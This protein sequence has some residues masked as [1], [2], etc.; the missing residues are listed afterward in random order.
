MQDSAELLAWLALIRIPGLDAR[1]ASAAVRRHGGAAAL[2]AAQPTALDEDGL[3]PSTLAALAR[4]D[5]AAAERDLAWLE[6]DDCRLLTCADPGYPLQLA[7]VPGA[8][9]ALFVRG[10]V[11]VL[12]RPQVAIVGSRQPT[13][14]GRSH[15]ARFATELARAGLA[16]T[17]GLALG[18]DACAHRAALEAGGAT[19]AVCGT[20][21]DRVYPPEHLDLALAIAAQGAVVSEFPPGTPPLAYNFPR[22]NRILA[23]LSL[24]VLVVEAAERSGSLITARLAAEMSREVFA[25]PGPID[26][27]LS[28]GCHRLLREGAQLVETPRELVAGLD[29]APL[30]QPAPDRAQPTVD[31]GFFGNALDT[32]YEMLLNALGFGPANID[33]LVDRTGLPASA[34]ASMLLILELGG[35]IE[36]LAGGRYCRVPRRST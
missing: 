29:F 20:G 13:G 25:V 5:L 4:P 26:S 12:D 14:A 19:V 1:R 30:A 31:T 17:S 24:G 7:S 9:C 27:P 10:D 33:S 22:R 36:S 15:A 11:A 16:I 3:P 6:R 18:I 2:L 8:P 35:D 23:G 34:V 21:L 28:R 32:R